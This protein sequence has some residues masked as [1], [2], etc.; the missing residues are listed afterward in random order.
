MN[1]LVVDDQY[2]VVQGVVGGVDWTGLGV[3]KVFK[4]YS[5]EQAC[6]V[7][8][9]QPIHVL[10]CDIELPPRNGFEVLDYI[11][12]R[13][14]PTQS[15]FLTAHASFE[16]ARTAVKKGG[17]DYILQPAPYEEIE[18][19][20]SKA[21]QRFKETQ[22]IEMEREYGRYWRE[23]EELLLDSCLVK[24][25]HSVNRQELNDLIENLKKL[26]ISVGRDTAV[27][28]TLLFS[29]VKSDW[30]SMFRLRLSAILDSLFPG[31]QRTYCIADMQEDGLLVLMMD[32]SVKQSDIEAGFEKLFRDMDAQKI[33]CYIGKKTTFEGLLQEY[34]ELCNRRHDNVAEYTGVFRASF[35]PAGNQYVYTRTDMQRWASYLAKGEWEQVR[36]EAL[37]ALKSN[38]DRGAI[39]AAYLA[40]F[41]QDFTQM[42][43]TAAKGH[44][45]NGH[46]F[47]DDYSFDDFLDA[48]TSYEKMVKLVE[49]ATGYIGMSTS[50]ET[51]TVSPVEQAVM[52]VQQHIDQNL[53]CQDIADAV[54]LN[55]S[56]LTR[57]F[58][59]EKGITLNDFITSEKMRVAASLLKVTKIPVSMIAI[60]VGYT[61]FSYFS[62][63]FR[64]S[65]G[66]SPLE[67]RQQN[68]EKTNENNDV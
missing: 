44:G 6:A 48:Y 49:F 11:H 27:L 61:S 19:A 25:L 31:Q 3:S 55:S 8:Q 58:K 23:K 67:Y 37:N 7:L 32:E 35:K 4:A 12:E 57:L 54:H 36:A 22:N 30:K 16:Y 46:I 51:V 68:V 39:D 50:G 60:K 65:T 20:V 53:S 43:L 59:K 17:F 64:K 42:F 38:R 2:D 66:L 62:Q 29:T 10:L 47:Y 1:V 21:L 63:V 56:H 13:D 24:Y 52:Y 41:H 28:P 40:R 45:S 14:L 15:I 34:I 26:R 5:V 9:E 33:A 18:Q